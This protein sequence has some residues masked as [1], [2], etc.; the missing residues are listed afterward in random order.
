M[1]R[2][3]LLMQQSH[4]DNDPHHASYR[5][6]F[7]GHEHHWHH[8]CIMTNPPSAASSRLRFS[9]PSKTSFPKPKKRSKP[10]GPTS[11]RIPNPE[12]LSAPQHS[13]P[14]NS[15]ASSFGVFFNKKGHNAARERSCHKSTP[16]CRT[17]RA[18]KPSPTGPTCLQSVFAQQSSE[19][20]LTKRPGIPLRLGAGRCALLSRASV[21]TARALI[22]F[23]AWALRE[24]ESTL[25]RSRLE[26]GFG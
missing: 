7:A 13:L 18:R 9:R 12:A 16:P 8:H 26:P 4:D 1:V 2:N 17:F 25:G 21:Q 15:Q 5:Q 11:P 19:R 20:I 14:R 3:I 24:P 23:T 22:P 6:T 10:R